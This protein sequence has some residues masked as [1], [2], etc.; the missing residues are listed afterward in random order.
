LKD[1]L[2]TKAVPK[3]HITKLAQQ[4]GGNDSL[5]AALQEQARRWL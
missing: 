3:I 1:A 4:L 5:R 2:P